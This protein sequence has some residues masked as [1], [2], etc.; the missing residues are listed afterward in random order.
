METRDDD[1]DSSSSSHSQRPQSLVPAGTLD[2]HWTS[3]EPPA[4]RLSVVI[5]LVGA[6][7]V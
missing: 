1:D 3:L 7:I 6:F 2:H 4:L 5:T